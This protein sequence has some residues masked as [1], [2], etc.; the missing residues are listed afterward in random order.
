MLRRFAGFALA[1]AAFSVYAFSEGDKAKPF[2]PNHPWHFSGLTGQHDLAQVQRGFQ[3]YW[4]KC[5]A[6]HGMEFRRFW[7]LEKVGYTETNSNP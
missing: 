2:A 5:A 4:A 7:H 1:V 3:V 6:C